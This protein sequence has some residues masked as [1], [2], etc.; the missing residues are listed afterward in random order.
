MEI[1][2]LDY[3]IYV[4]YAKQKVVP[5]DFSIMGDSFLFIFNKLKM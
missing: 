1:R 2:N 5:D 4:K 3:L